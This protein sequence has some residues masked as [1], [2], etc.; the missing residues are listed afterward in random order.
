VADPVIL[1]VTGSRAL[2]DTQAA[3]EWASDKIL[4]I[5]CEYPEKNELVVTGCA[6][7]AD[8]IAAKIAERALV[9]HRLGYVR[10]IGAAPVLPRW[11]DDPL[12]VHGDRAAW[13]QRLLARDRAM[14]QWVAAQP[15]PKR[16][17]ALLAP[18]SRTQGTAYTAAQAERA[19]IAVTRLVCPV[20]LGPGGGGSDG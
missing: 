16:C 4:G 14:V 19:G 18:W 2:D 10:I 5:I 8:A 12:P 7:G 20:N 15:G 1:L 11:C 13:K 6:R 3:Y 9:F 17:L